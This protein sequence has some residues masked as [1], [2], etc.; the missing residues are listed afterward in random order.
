FV[1]HPKIGLFQPLT[2]GLQLWSFTNHASYLVNPH[3]GGHAVLQ[4]PIEIFTIV[5]LDVGRAP[6]CLFLLRHDRPTCQ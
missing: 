5:I 3:A 4:Q 6:L 2:V 1:I